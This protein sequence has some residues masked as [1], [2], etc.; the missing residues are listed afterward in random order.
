MSSGTLDL[1]TDGLV[2]GALMFELVAQVFG[3]M[4][5]QNT[6]APEGRENREKSGEKV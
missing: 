2:S 4:G 6:T 3:W 5:Q 1:R